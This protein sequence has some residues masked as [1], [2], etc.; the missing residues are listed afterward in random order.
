MNTIYILKAFLKKDWLLTKKQLPAM[1]FGLLMTLFSLGIFFFIGKIVNRTN[2]TFFQIYAMDYFS[3][4]FIGVIFTW[5][6]FLILDGAVNSFRE[7]WQKGI[8]EVMLGSNISPFV[9]LIGFNLGNILAVTFQSCFLFSLGKFIFHLPLQSFNLFF[10][11]MVLVVNNLILLVLCLILSAFSLLFSAQRNPLLFLIQYGTSFFCGVYF[12]L[13]YLPEKLQWIAK[14]LPFTY[15]ID[16]LRSI[17]FKTPGLYT[18]GE[19]MLFLGCSLFFLWGLGLGLINFAVQ[20][21]KE[22]GKLFI[23]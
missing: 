8:L 10:L 20:R 19:T 22:K 15:I 2:H 3:F 7:Y 5:Q 21:A 6:L 18:P 13:D 17:L 1:A 16:S 14:W 4:V 9:L 12:P 23:Y 11:F